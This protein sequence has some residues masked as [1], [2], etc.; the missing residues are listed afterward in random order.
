MCALAAGR[1]EGQMAAWPHCTKG[2]GCITQRTLIQI[3]TRYKTLGSLWSCL[4]LAWFVNPGQPSRPATPCAAFTNIPITCRSIKV[5]QYPEYGIR[6]TVHVRNNSRCFTSGFRL[7]SVTQLSP[8]LDTLKPG[9]L[10]RTNMGSNGTAAGLSQ[11]SIRAESQ[12]PPTYDAFS[13]HHTIL[14]I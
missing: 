11:P 9:A 10:E 2:G 6:N 5:V 14:C 8:A 7:I 12:S 1:V 3:Q 4:W 13:S